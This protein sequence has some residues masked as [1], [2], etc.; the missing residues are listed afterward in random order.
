[1]SEKFNIF[2]PNS[3]TV[4][5]QRLHPVWGGGRLQGSCPCPFL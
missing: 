5:L 2:A 1:M 3:Y 4:E